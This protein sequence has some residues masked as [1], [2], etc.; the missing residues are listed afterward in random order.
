MFFRRLHEDEPTLSCGADH[1]DMH[2][3]TRLIGDDTFYLPPVCLKY[4]ALRLRQIEKYGKEQ[5][6]GRKQHSGLDLVVIKIVSIPRHLIASSF[7]F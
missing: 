7:D 5:L 3:S 1:Y 4:R 6:I 2:T